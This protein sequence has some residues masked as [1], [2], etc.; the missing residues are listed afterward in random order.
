MIYLLLASIAWAF[1]FGI[2]KTSLGNLDDFFVAF[3]RLA[4]ALP[5]FLP[6]LR[7]RNLLTSD[8]FKLMF[9]GMVQY[10]LTYLFYLSA[11]KY[12]DSYQIALFTVTTPIYVTLIHDIYAGKFN[13]IAL[14][15]AILAV[16]GALVIKY[17]ADVTGALTGFGLMQISCLCFAFGQIA[18]KR[19]RTQ[20]PSWVDSKV[21]AFLYLGAV[22]ITALATQYSG[23]WSSAK[24]L[25]ANQI[26]AL[27]YL[28]AIATGIS[29]F[30]WNKGAVTTSAG[31]LAVF[32]NMKIPLAV[33]VSLTI[34]NESTDLLR[35]LLGGGL[36]ILAA[37]GSE[38][39]A[40]LPS[41]K[42]SNTPVSGRAQKA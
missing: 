14:L 16:C 18:Y 10:G 25:T 3:A 33:L 7:T 21:Y 31:T 41:E 9:I 23:G 6:F 27:L 19:L 17:K 11:F 24:L 42:M 12:L 28:G 22:I 35:L 32:N 38:K 15:M 34:F 29:F 8:K 40:T 20:N 1:S 36:M 5:I 26:Y 30:W 39:F 13:P 37:W 4:I 2:I